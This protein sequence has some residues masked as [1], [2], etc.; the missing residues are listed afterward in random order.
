MNELLLCKKLKHF[1][2]EYKVSGHNVTLT[3]I[4]KGIIFNSNKELKLTFSCDDLAEKFVTDFTSLK[5]YIA[6]VGEA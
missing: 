4:K 1:D 6:G 3:Y 5:T 2:K